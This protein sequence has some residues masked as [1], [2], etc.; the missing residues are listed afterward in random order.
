MTYTNRSR[1]YH[2]AAGTVLVGMGLSAAASGQN[3]RVM[4]REH[5]VRNPGKIMELPAPPGDYLPKT[6]EEL[7]RESDVV[8]QG[9]LVF[10]RSYLLN[11]SEDRVLSDYRL[12]SPRVLAGAFDSVLSP[13][14]GPGA[15][16]RIVVYGGEIQLEG[17]RVRATDYNSAPI[18]QGQ[19]Y[20]L[21]LRHSRLKDPGL[22]E[23]YYGG[24][25]EVSGTRLKPLLK[26][27]DEVFEGS[28][29]ASLP[30]VIDRVQKAKPR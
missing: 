1:M 13:T 26:R 22:Y 16:V 3:L 9:T 25:F 24:I 28:K 27:G 6:F 19:E 12:A 21:F 2:F 14:P 7:S 20:L 5:A 11:P 30:E 10:V 17:V 23:I 15:P 18:V 29:N 8:V 4:A